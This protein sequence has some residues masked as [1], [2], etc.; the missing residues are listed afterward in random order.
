MLHSNCTMRNWLRTLVHVAFMI[1]GLMPA[2]AQN[3]GDVIYVY[4]K[5]GNIL[6]FLRE[7]IREMAFIYEDTLGIT[8]DEINS[9]VIILDD[10]AQIIPLTDIDSISFVT[11]PTVYKSGVIRLEE[12]LMQYVER[13]DSLTIYFA[14]NTPAGL[15]PKV[16]DKLVTTEINDKFEAG[17]AGV[18]ASVNGKTVV[19]NAVALEEVFDTFYD[20]TI[21]EGQSAEQDDSEARKRINID[22]SI[23]KTFD[24]PTYSASIGNELTS[25]ISPFSSLAYKVGTKLEVSF[26]PKIRIK[27]SLIVNKQQGT[28]FNASADLTTTLQ[29]SISFYGGLE[30]SFQFGWEAIKV[31][32]G[33]Y[34]KFY[35]K[36][37]IFYDRGVTASISNVWEQRF[38]TYFSFSFRDKAEQPFKH[39]ILNH[40]PTSSQDL[41]GCIDGRLAGG[42]FTEV[43]FAP[44]IMFGSSFAN[45]SLHSEFGKE[46]VGHAVLYNND[47]KNATKETKAYE[48]LRSSNIQ[49]NDFSNHE[50]QVKILGETRTNPI[51][52]ISK[53]KEQWDLVPRFT[54]ISTERKDNVVEVTLNVEKSE[55]DL[56]MPVDFGVALYNSNDELV[57]KDYLGNYLKGSDGGTFTNFFKDLDYDE[58]YTVSPIVKILGFELRATESSDVD[59]KDFPVRIVSFKQ[60]GSSYSDKQE[61]VYEGKQYYYK[62]NATTTVEINPET[63]KVKDWGYI[64]HDI[65]GVDKKISCANLGSNPYADTRYAYYYNK[66]ERTV[67]LTPYI[68]FEGETE[69]KKGSAATYNLKHDDNGIVGTWYTWVTVW[70]DEMLKIDGYTRDQVDRRLEVYTLRSDG[71]YDFGYYYY[72][73][74]WESGPRVWKNE[75]K[76]SGTYEVNGDILTFSG[77]PGIYTSQINNSTIQVVGDQ[78]WYGLFYGSDGRLY[79]YTLYRLKDENDEN[80]RYKEEQKEIRSILAGD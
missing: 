58:E 33:K 68:Q 11:P 1:L 18:V 10:Y 75:G 19:C 14:A 29:E 79:G 52:G 78:L 42:L 39:E 53:K 56:V 32:I 34:V 59:K 80:N 44:N 22:A 54:S 48:M 47:I 72:P 30:K 63:K 61:F 69:I 15:L 31:P 77:Y 60:T 62:F 16:G 40:E 55:D 64:Y 57:S 73:G 65:Y 20:T 2:S 25:N 37:G 26:T 21:M 9:Q 71:T 28:V 3:T 24:F 7:E 51:G 74:I 35:F 4:Q 70:T 43:G 5:D 12:G 36:A 45:A 50:L 41:I 6:S 66:S 46:I 27:S 67:N 17:F 23:D 38:G 8:H 76:D 13:C 49:V